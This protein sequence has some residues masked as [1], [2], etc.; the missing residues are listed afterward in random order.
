MVSHA[1]KEHMN[2]VRVRAVILNYERAEL[3][4]RSVSSMLEQNYPALDVVVVDNHS[5]DRCY[6]ALRA[7]LPT[8]VTL[9]RTAAN[10]GYARGNNAGMFGPTLPPPDY[11]WVVNNDVVF[12]DH[13]TCR[14]LVE[15]I[16]RDPRSACASPLV[17]TSDAGALPPEQIQVRRVPDY[18]TVLISSSWWLRRL[19]IFRR[20]V[21]AYTYA[22]IR[23][24]PTDSV[25]SVET[26]NGSCFLIEGEFA[27][28][29]GGFD[30][31]T[32]LYQEELILGKQLEQHGR[33]ACL[34]TST[35]VQHVQGATTRHRLG[36][37]RFDMARH[38]VESE[39]YYCRKYLNASRLQ[40]AL[41]VGTRVVDVCTKAAYL[42]M[43]RRFR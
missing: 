17:D 3:T 9:V 4:L 20:T 32:F 36:A 12:P 15:A 7:G 26:V 29:I 1:R 35:T 13:G 40:Q 5:S 25:I 19:P 10:V 18:K 8:G 30:P 16:R 14:K 31:G 38:M 27:R 41:L 39:L 33:T 42:R 37:F 24:Y 28:S 43:S 22:D 6:E 23:P 21:D 11:Y 34:V 2:D